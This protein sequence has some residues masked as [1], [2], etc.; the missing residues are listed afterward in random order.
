MTFDRSTNIAP[1][2]LSADF[3]NFGREC[4]AIEAQG[5]FH[6]AQISLTSNTGHTLAQMA[7]RF[8]SGRDELS[9]GAREL[10]D[11]LNER[12][13]MDGLLLTALGKSDTKSTQRLNR[14]LAQ[15]DGRSKAATKRMSER[16]PAYSVGGGEKVA[17]LAH[18]RRGLYGAP[19]AKEVGSWFDSSARRLS[20]NTKV[21]PSR[22]LRAQSR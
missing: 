2:I 21:A 18:R 13:T 4:E 1:S 12:S 9:Q 8:A 3:A 16:F 19:E 14:D 11:L 22:S 5:A 7:T 6:I 20:R 17:H 15:I 10:Q